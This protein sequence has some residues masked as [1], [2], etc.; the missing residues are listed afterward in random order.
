MPS[1]RGRHVRA[2]NRFR[3]LA[4]PR[5]SAERVPGHTTRPAARGPAPGTSRRSRPL[6]GRRRAL[7]LAAP[8][9]FLVY[10]VWSYVGWASLDVAFL[11][12]FFALNAALVTCFL[13]A[14]SS[15]RSF[16]HLPAAHGRV[17]CI[18]PVY[19]EEDHLVHAA[20]RALLR[21]TILPDEIHVVDDGSVT[22]LRPF[23]DPLVQW[24]RI[25]NSGKRHAQAHVLRRF[26]P[27]EFDFVLTVDSD[28]VLDDDALERMLE[29]MSDDRVQ[30]CTGMILMRNWDVNLLTRLTDI[31]VVCSCLLFRTVRSWLGIVSPTSGAI[32]LYRAA[33]IYDNLDDYVSSGTAGDDRRLSF[34]ALLRGQVVGVNEAVVETQLPTTWDGAFLQR[35]RWSKSAWLGTGFVWTNLRWVVV[36]FY[37]FPLVFALLWPLTVA[38]LI[39]LS[40]RFGNPALAYGVLYWVVCAVTQTAVYAVYRPSLTLAQRLQQWALSPVYPV[41][42]LVIL[43]P[44]AYAALTKLRSTSWHT[45]EVALPAAGAR[46][47]A[48]VP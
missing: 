13:L 48:P 12:G 40:I 41:F 16:S 32:A 17:L 8:A 26:A 39:T 43:R 20:V 11:V 47:D 15:W 19:N 45:R 28:S 31:N 24:H 22:P 3:P 18:V 21:Q 25:A 6:H 7:A 27:R 30:A 14:G 35:M 46:A 42:G 38:V 4:G 44:A 1:T 29:A 23:D 10:A 36:L 9:M 34:Y 5:R 37:T 2:G 33:V